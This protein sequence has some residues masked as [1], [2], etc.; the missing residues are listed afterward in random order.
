M[1]FPTQSVETLLQVAP[2][3]K[4]NSNANNIFFI[5]LNLKGADLIFLMEC[6]LIIN[7]IFY[8]YIFLIL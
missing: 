5:L 8:C 7:L 2:Q 3:N 6:I 1:G 4:N